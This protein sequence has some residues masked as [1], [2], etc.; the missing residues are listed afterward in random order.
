M[1]THVIRHRDRLYAL[2][3]TNGQIVRLRS[4]KGTDCTLEVRQKTT[5]S[6]TFLVLFILSCRCPLPIVS[7][8]N[9]I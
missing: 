8:L 1:H 9:P 4:D 2:D 7:N 5:A 6:S 3:Q